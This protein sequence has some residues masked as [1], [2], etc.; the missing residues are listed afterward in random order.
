MRA[1]FGD[2]RDAGRQLAIIG[3]RHGDD[4]SVIVLGVPRGGVPVAFEVAQARHAPNGVCLIRQITAAAPPQ[5]ADAVV[6]HATM[7]LDGVGSWYPTFAPRTDSEVA[8]LLDA[9]SGAAYRPEPTAPYAA[10]QE[11][12]KQ[13]I[14]EAGVR[15]LADFRRPQ[16]MWRDAAVW[17]FVGWRKGVSDLR[18]DPAS[19]VGFFGLDR[20][21]CFRPFGHDAVVYKRVAQLGCG[22]DCESVPLSLCT[23]A[24]DRWRSAPTAYDPSSESSLLA[25]EHHARGTACSG[26]ALA[27]VGCTTYR[28][29]AFAAADLG[30]PGRHMTV[31]PAVKGSVEWL[32]HQMGLPAFSKTPRL[33]SALA[34][35]FELRRLFRAI[36]V[37]YRPK[38]ERQSH[39]VETARS[40]QFDTIRHDDGTRTVELLEKIA[41]AV[42]AALPGTYP[43]ALIMRA[44]RGA[45]C[46]A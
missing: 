24:Q 6:V 8:S 28:G 31:R 3:Y 44:P 41:D 22:P 35:S 7:Q 21:P 38:T 43:T 23:A 29:S 11:I 34:E 10:R 33:D 30:H 20:Y 36:G 25:L 9:E 5:F 42:T 12:T 17:D 1:H 19:A 39:D 26:S 4:P 13:R 15:A 18:A 45:R 37:V 16:R 32:M 46:R 27:F 14:F 2:R 40:R